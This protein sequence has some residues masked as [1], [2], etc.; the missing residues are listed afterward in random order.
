MK[1]VVIK[2]IW[3]D[4]ETTSCYEDNEDGIYI[5]NYPDDSEP[6]GK[7]IDRVF[8]VLDSLRGYDLEDKEVVA[9]FSDEEQEA[10]KEMCSWY[11]NSNPKTETI[12]YISEVPDWFDNRGCSLES[13]LLENNLEPKLTYQVFYDFNTQSAT[14]KVSD[15]KLHDDL[16][17]FRGIT[18]EQFIERT[19]NFYLNTEVPEGDGTI[20]YK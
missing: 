13:V 20:I 6:Y 4:M 8:N 10:Y 2:S 18:S 12:D 5:I 1:R 15:L 19:I 9:D 17:D 7:V 3:G 11:K 16:M 14:V